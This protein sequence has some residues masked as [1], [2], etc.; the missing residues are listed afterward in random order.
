MSEWHAD[1]AA[2]RN[3]CEQRREQVAGLLLARTPYRQMA[4]MLNVALSTIAKDVQ[5]IRKRWVAS[6]LHSY[7]QHVSEQAALLDGLERAMAP[8][9]L[10][11]DARAAEV[12]LRVMERR[13]R[14]LGLDRPVRHEVTG[15]DGGPIVMT[16]TLAEE[17]EALVDELALRRAALAG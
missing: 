7:E 9:A 11:G 16:E 2:A 14:L 15:V 4:S 6:S 1:V 3:A 17:A 8:K 10:L 5:I 12:L 13:A